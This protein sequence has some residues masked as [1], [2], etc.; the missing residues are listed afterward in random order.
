VKLKIKMQKAAKKKMEE[1]ESTEGRTG[2]GFAGSYAG[3][4]GEGRSFEF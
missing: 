1:R 3:A 4:R 2:F